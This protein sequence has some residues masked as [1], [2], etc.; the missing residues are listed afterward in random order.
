MVLPGSASLPPTS[1]T[2]SS[3]AGQGRGGCTPTHP[4]PPT[5]CPLRCPSPGLATEAG[6]GGSSILCEGGSRGGEGPEPPVTP[7][8]AKPPHNGISRRHVAGG[9]CARHRPARSRGVAP[10]IRG[11]PTAPAEVSPHPPPPFPGRPPAPL[12]GCPDLLDH[13]S[14]RGRRRRR[15][16]GGQGGNRQIYW[17]QSVRAGPARPSRAS[18]DPLMN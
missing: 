1:E 8:D 5:L 13:L 2:P 14:G 15:R 12:C 3:H 9:Q 17:P 7:P 18:L 10:G 11:P 4:Q 6:V 16:R